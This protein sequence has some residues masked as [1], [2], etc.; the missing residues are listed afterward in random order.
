[1]NKHLKKKKSKI[2][3]H[4][5]FINE[6]ETDEKY[7]NDDIF[8]KYFKYQSPL[9]LAKDLFKVKNNKLVNNINDA[10]VDLRNAIIIGGTLENENA[11]KIVDIV[12]KI[13]DFNK[14]Q[15]CQGLP[16]DFYC[17]QL[18]ILSLNKCFKDYQ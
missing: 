8:W 17:S 2:R 5:E 15:K 9:F 16:L 10:L 18:K 3:L 6:I 12:E 14:Q 13:L 11:N 1:M 4:K 7:I